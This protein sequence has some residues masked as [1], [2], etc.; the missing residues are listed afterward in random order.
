M[1]NTRGGV[2]IPDVR[3]MWHQAV[4]HSW[5][6]VHLVSMPDESILCLFFLLEVTSKPLLIPYSAFLAL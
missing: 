2:T 1:L 6:L 3:S 4:V 5:E